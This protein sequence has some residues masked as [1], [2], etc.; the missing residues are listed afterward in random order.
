MLGKKVTWSS[1]SAGYTKEKTGFVVLV[2]PANRIAN[3][4]WEDLPEEERLKYTK[5][6]KLFASTMRTVTSYVVAVP[7][8]SGKGRPNLYWPLTSTLRF[9]SGGPCAR[10]NFGADET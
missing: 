10:A 1:Q 4:M 3:I 7:T 5:P 8:P 9:E 6:K 2:V